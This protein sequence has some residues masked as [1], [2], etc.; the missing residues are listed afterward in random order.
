MS[1][2]SP[3]PINLIGFPVIVRIESAAPPRASPSILVR[4]IPSMPMCSSKFFAIVTASCPVIASA[5]RITSFGRTFSFIFLNSAIRDSSIWSLPAVSRI[6]ISIASS[7]D[8]LIDSS[9]RATGSLVSFD[10]YTG[11]FIC[12][13][14]VMSCSIAAGLCRSAA[15]S[16]GLLPSF[17]K[18]L[19]SFAAVVVFPEPCKPM[20]IMTVGGFGE[21]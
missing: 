18:F 10:E 15:T 20:S 19:A 6:T 13:P 16:R 3:T 4:M 21:S 11:T 7:F 1:I 2:F 14:R 17:L 8:F 5:I 12:A 9:H